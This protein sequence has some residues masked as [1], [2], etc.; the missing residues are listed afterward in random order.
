[1]NQQEL[2]KLHLLFIIILLSASTVF[3]F[4]GYRVSCKQLEQDVRINNH[5]I[6]SD[7]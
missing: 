7:Q 3:L 2:F 4:L 1:M 5:I 6:T